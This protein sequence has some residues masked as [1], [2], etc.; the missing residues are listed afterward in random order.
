MSVPSVMYGF[1]YSLPVLLLSIALRN[2]VLAIVFSKI[3]LVGDF[4]NL[5]QF[6]T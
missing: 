2:K 1:K 4:Q 5:V 6:L 3:I